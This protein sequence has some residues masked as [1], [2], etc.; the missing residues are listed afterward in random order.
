[1]DQEPTSENRRRVRVKIKTKE[2]YRRTSSG[3]S[4]RSFLKL[5]GQVLLAIIAFVV[6]AFVTFRVLDSV[7]VPAKRK[8]DK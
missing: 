7:N 2:K 3:P 6:F 5:A 8:G 1:M 4:R